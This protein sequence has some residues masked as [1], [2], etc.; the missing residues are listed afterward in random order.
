MFLEE[1]LS[2]KLYTLT[3]WIVFGDFN[4]IYKA[5]NKNNLSLNRR[6]MGRFRHTLDV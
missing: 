3:P 6:L 4:L 2:L 1:L 5:T